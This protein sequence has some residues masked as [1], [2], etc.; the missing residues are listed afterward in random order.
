MMLFLADEER[1]QVERL[2][3]PSRGYLQELSEYQQRRRQIRKS[4]CSIMWPLLDALR[5][6]REGEKQRTQD[7]FTCRRKETYV[8]PLVDSD[9]LYLHMNFDHWACDIKRTAVNSHRIW[10]DPVWRWLIEPF[11]VDTVSSVQTITP[12]WC[13]KLPLRWIEPQ[14]IKQGRVNLILSPEIDISL[15]WSAMFCHGEISFFMNSV[16]TP[17]IWLE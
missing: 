13:N 1:E 4:R 11:Y 15:S 12:D 7:S 2:R 16:V 8:W 14:S 5:T 9:I 17:A 6:G 3:W 10:A